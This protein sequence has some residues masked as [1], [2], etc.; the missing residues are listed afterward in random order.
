M[1]SYKEK[2]DKLNLNVSDSNNMVKIQ[3][4]CNT[5]T[6]VAVSYR[7]EV[8]KT[9]HCG[10]IEDL[11]EAKNLKGRTLKFVGD[12]NNPDNGTI[13]VQHKIYEEGGES[14]IYTFP[15]DYTGDPK[16]DSTDNHPL[17]KFSINYKQVKQ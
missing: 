7:G 16:Y 10:K 4:D 13:N 3:V 15:D 1:A 6:V 14:V 8:I 9:V 2:K 5:G 17:Y 11:G 12:A